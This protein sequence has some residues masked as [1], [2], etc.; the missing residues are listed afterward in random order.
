MHCGG[1]TQKA[2]YG[3]CSGHGVEDNEKGVSDSKKY[4]SGFMVIGFRI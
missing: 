1:K 2:Y 4:L 3:G